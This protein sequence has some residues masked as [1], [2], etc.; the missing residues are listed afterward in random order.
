MILC[1]EVYYQSRV[2][3]H[4]E[5]SNR[6]NTIGRENERGT[7]SIRPYWVIFNFQDYSMLL[8]SRLLTCTW[9]HS[10]NCNADRKDEQNSDNHCNAYY[11]WGNQRSVA[12]K[13]LTHVVTFLVK[14]IVMFHRVI[15][16]QPS[17]RNADRCSCFSNIYIV[18][19]NGNRLIIKTVFL[20]IRSPNKKE[21]KKCYKINK[22]KFILH[23]ENL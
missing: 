3:L 4:V 18:K 21:I 9:K 12:A 7:Q 20:N 13:L 6:K 16:E 15:I 19:I 10:S 1:L 17:R 8:E 5:K 23:I 11:Y 14:V 2:T 22:A